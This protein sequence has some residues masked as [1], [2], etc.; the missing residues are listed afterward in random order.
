MKALNKI[1][2]VLASIE[3]RIIRRQAVKR[4]ARVAC[5]I[6]LSGCRV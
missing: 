4:A 1:I 5:R 3:I 2:E 6:A